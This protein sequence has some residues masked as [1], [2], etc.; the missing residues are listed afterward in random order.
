MFESSALRWYE[1]ARTSVVVGYVKEMT[2]NKSCNYGDSVSFE[3][4]L[5]LS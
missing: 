1:E 2:T 5:F 3:H 4:S